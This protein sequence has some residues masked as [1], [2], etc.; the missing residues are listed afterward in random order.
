LQKVTV[1]A[2]SLNPGG[3]LERNS[4]GFIGGRQSGSA[5]AECDPP[6]WVG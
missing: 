5:K 1:K 6:A 2:S 3:D 4:W